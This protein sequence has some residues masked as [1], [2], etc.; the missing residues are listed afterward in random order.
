[1]ESSIDSG[2]LASVLGELM[3]NPELESMVNE[4]RSKLTG[5]NAD[6]TPGSGETDGG[7]GG[8]ASSQPSLAESQ[9]SP[10]G[11]SHGFGI[12]PDIMEKLPSIMSGLSGGKSPPKKSGSDNMTRLMRALKPYLSGRR[13]DA[14]DSII[15]IAELGSLANLIPPKKGE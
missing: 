1:M 12:P 7:S 4:L 8:E 6:G 3:K 14:I 13:K 5:A 11:V 10:S 2:S 9:P 15:T